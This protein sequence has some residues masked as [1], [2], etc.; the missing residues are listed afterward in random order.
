MPTLAQRWPDVFVLP[1]IYLN[2]FIGHRKGVRLFQFCLL[3]VI[4]ALH[5]I[6]LI[7]LLIKN[8]VMQIKMASYYKMRLLVLE[9]LR[10]I[11]VLSLIC[12]SD[13]DLGGWL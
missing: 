6:A 13:N 5:R 2:S 4:V 7:Q 10:N 12:Y 9:L 1:G 3:S 11:V 8:E